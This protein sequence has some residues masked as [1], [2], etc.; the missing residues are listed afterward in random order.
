MRELAYFGATILALFYTCSCRSESKALALKVVEVWSLLGWT[1]VTVVSSQKESSS[2]SSQELEAALLKASEGVRVQFTRDHD[3]PGIPRRKDHTQMTYATFI[4]SHGDEDEDWKSVVRVIEMSKGYTVLLVWRRQPPSWN[5]HWDRV[6]VPLGFFTLAPTVGG[7]SFSF[8]KV[9]T[10]RDGSSP[11]VKDVSVAQQQR[12]LE[13]V[14]GAH[15]EMSTLNYA[16]YLLFGTCDLSGRCGPTPG[17]LLL[18]AMDLIA[19]L[20]NFTYTL[21]E[22]PSKKWGYLSSN[23]TSDSVSAE[24]VIPSVIRDLNDCALSTWT[25]TVERKKWVDFTFNVYSGNYRCFA[26]A[27]LLENYGDTALL[28]SPFTPMAWI[29]ASLSF[30][31]LKG[32]TSYFS[33]STLWAIRVLAF[34]CGILQVFLAGFYEGALTM[35]LASKAGAPF[36]SMYMGLSQGTWEVLLSNGDES[37][38]LINFDQERLPEL[39][40]QHRKVTSEEYLRQDRTLFKV[41]GDLQTKQ[42]HFT[43]INRDRFLW[44]M[45]RHKDVFT[46]HTYEFCEHVFTYGALMIPKNSPYKNALNFWILKLQDFG[47][48][49]QLK[50]SIELPQ[51]RLKEATSNKV[52]LRQ[53]ALAFKSLAVILATVLVLLAMEMVSKKQHTSN[54]TCPTSTTCERQVADANLKD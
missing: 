35:F 19:E 13:D 44:A 42:H 7:R 20:A 50:N 32:V 1:N 15:L 2:S 27:D 4:L 17:G 41:L 22:D 39:R 3:T 25:Y 18:R 52:T 16:P 49:D 5:Q 43:I 30:A 9:M 24:G 21:K 31:T 26:N 10:S 14:S 28:M 53:L 8:Q 48:L 12:I 51:G 54:T 23:F 46:F 36:E 38:I 40:E 37:F 6:R 34:S 29:F 33:P 47:I 45:G 11:I